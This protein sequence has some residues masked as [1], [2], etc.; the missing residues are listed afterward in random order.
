MDNT[1]PHG[2]FMT[3]NKN[4]IKA[5]NLVLSPLSIIKEVLMA[6]LLEHLHQIED[7]REQRKII[8]PKDE[9]NCDTQSPIL[10]VKF[11]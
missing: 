9:F 4:V 8:Y 1:M 5:I 6:D 7:S 3:R 11:F 2:I 10:S